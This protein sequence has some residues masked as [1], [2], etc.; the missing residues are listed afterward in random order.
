MRIITFLLLMWSL[1]LVNFSS[2]PAFCAETNENPLE[3][4]FLVSEP[5]GLVVFVDT[6]AGRPH[7]TEWLSKWYFDQT[8][9]AKTDKEI[10][11]EYSKLLSDIGNNYDAKDSIG[12]QMDLS[13]R[14]KC[15]SMHFLT[16]DDLLVELKTLLKPQEYALFE[17]TYKQ[18]ES[19]YHE[20][21]FLPRS[22]RLKAQFADFNNGAKK[23]QMLDKLE[24]VRRFFKSDWPE[25]TAFDVALIPLPD[26]K[27]TSS[28]GESIGK[29][30]IVELLTTADFT[31]QGETVFHEL[32]HAIWER[33]KLDKKLIKAFDRY[34]FDRDYQV[35]NESLATALSQGLFHDKTFPESK[36]SDVWYGNEVIDKFAHGL[37]PLINEYLE[38]EQS[39]DSEF[40]RRA[41]KIFELIKE[42]R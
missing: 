3:I 15:L 25:R 20:K 6:L 17:K 10:C 39:I 42:K 5:C 41:D 33:K 24:Q 30:Q 38:K 23:Y 34:N 7:N 18:F 27:Q 36:Q 11:A 9:E 31:D 28:H 32:C 29:T 40:V 8:K 16:L 4:R 35:M 1:T 14:I 21:V 19:F 22:Q 2:C 12:R 37:Y 13:Q 26:E